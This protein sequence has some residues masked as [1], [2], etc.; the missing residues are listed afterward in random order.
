VAIDI[1]LDQPEI[2]NHGPKSGH[3]RR[4]TSGKAQ[5]GAK[6]H[7]SE[8][9]SKDTDNSKGS[10]GKTSSHS[11]MRKKK[12]KKSKSHDPEEFRKAKPPTFN[13]YIK[14]GA[15]AEVWLLD[16]KK[17]FRVHDYSENLKAQIAI[18]NLNGKASIWWE[19]L[20]NVK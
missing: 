17:Y 20:R 19:D 3:T 9:S 11:Q 18:F 4:R 6:R 13:G 7:S 12:R 5:R 16:L 15:E 8:Y 10:S 14:K 2:Q 1:H